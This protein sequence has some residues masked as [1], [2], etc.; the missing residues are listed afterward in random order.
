MIYLKIQE[1]ISARKAKWGRRVTL[2]EVTNSTGIRRMTLNRM[3]RQKGY[4]TVT[5]HLDKLCT[6]F[7]CDIHELMK[8]IP[9]NNTAISQTRAEQLSGERKT[10]YL[11]VLGDVMNKKLGSIVLMLIGSSTSFAADQQ[12]IIPAVYVTVEKLDGSLEDSRLNAADSSAL[13]T[14]RPGV[15]LYQGGGVSSL[16]VIRGL[17]DD[18]I[19]ILVD[20][21]ELTSA[22]GNH[23][24]PP[25]SYISPTSVESINVLAGITPVSM[26]GDSI[27][28]TI[29]VSSAKPAF[30]TGDGLLYLGSFSTYYR[31]NNNGLS[32]ALGASIASE[33][34][35][36]GFTGTI[37]HANSYEDG[38]G[39]KVRSTQFDRRTQ[40]FTLGAKGEDQ[41]FTLRVGHQDI[42]Y[43]GY[44]NQYMDMVG[45]QSNFINTNYAR[46][47][48]WGDLDTRI[49]WQEVSHEM[50]FFS[51]EKTGT[52]PMKTRGQDYGYAIKTTIPFAQIHTLRIGNEFHR[53]KLDDHWPPVAGSMMM[54]PLSF[55]NINDG[56]RDRFGVYAEVE[57]KWNPQWSTL[58]GV[59]DD[60]VR[61]NTGDVHGYA[62][63][64]M[65]SAADIAAANVFNASNH[66]KSDNHID[67]TATT[68]FEPGQAHAVKFGYARKT[69]SPSL[70]ERYSWGRGTMAMSMIGWFGDAN[71]YVGNLDLK[72]EVANTVSATL[73]WHDINK[74]DWELNLTPYYTYVQDYIGVNRIGTFHPRN[75]ASET[76]ALLQFDN[77]DAQFYGIDMFWK[78]GVWDNAQ[79]GQARLYG[80]LG[81]ARGERV[82]DGAD[83][84]HIMPLNL[85]MTMEQKISAWTNAIEFHLVERK[86]HVDDQRFEAKTSGY[87]LMNLR[88][89]YQWEKARL[90]LGVTNLLDK[91]YYLPLGG[92]DYADWKAG[93]SIGQM[94]AVAG[95]GR[96]L[97]VGLTLKF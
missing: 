63:T 85:R 92:V 88:T 58:L 97:N 6:Y 1:L 52:M 66:A 84:Y 17:N 79:F 15:N 51:S 50:G 87:A 10:N 68:K 91:F 86:T 42:P 69:R 74:Q 20:G 60:Y 2:T 11:I 23:M 95:M 3:M 35:S 76:K 49:Y 9:N 77:Q 55:I 71:G 31:S 53:N 82:S 45:N 46:Q 33:N 13:L 48:A 27:A 28:G 59:R 78:R 18:R 26:G 93:G 64:G 5:D 29:A 4:N 7:E 37:D 24:N 47:F 61:S 62:F 96:S 70:Y 22:C 89:S 16:P 8:F 12:L 32:S 81:W 21:A 94:S 80:S 34:L 43:Q 75:A 54:G 19:K 56:H 90:D 83:L 25:L 14:N 30:A 39:N 44:V 41:Q 65:M 57:S 72:P 40:T 67:L 73:A 36:L 38:H